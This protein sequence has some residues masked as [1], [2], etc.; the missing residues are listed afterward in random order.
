MADQRCRVGQAKN[1]GVK[2]F[3]PS[4]FGVDHRHIQHPFFEEKVKVFEAVQQ[5]NF[6]DGKQLNSIMRHLLELTNSK[7]FVGWTAIGS[8]FFDFVIPAFVQVLPESSTITFRGT[9]QK[10][11]P[12]TV[13]HDI[14]QVLA[15]SFKDPAAFKDKW[16]NVAN[17]WLSLRQIANTINQ[18]S[19]LGFRTESV[20]VDENV[21]VLQIFEAGDFNVFEHSRQATELP[22]KLSDL[23]SRLTWS[24]EAGIGCWK[25]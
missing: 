18:Q 4:E 7:H 5:A 20:D 19:N 21:P 17:A 14:G 11:F 10:Q 23:A 2:R 12:F 22:V 13:A 15:Q 6:P 16:L 25:E 24:P 8:G 3:V 9:G 1:D